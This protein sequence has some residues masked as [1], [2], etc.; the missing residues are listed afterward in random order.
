MSR[1]QAREVEIL[2]ADSDIY[3]RT[4]LLSLVGDYSF[5]WETQIIVWYD[6][7]KEKR[8]LKV[9]TN[10]VSLSIAHLGLNHSHC[11]A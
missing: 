7:Y 6:F 3:K 9:E 8:Y 10:M 4:K 5:I 2:S 1:R 11:S